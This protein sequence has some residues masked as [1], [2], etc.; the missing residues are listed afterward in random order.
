MT[1]KIAIVT[2]AARGIGKAITLRLLREG[3]KIMA[4]DKDGVGLESLLKELDSDLSVFPVNIA[5]YEHVERFF[6]Q[7]IESDSTPYA[8]VNNAGIFPGTPFLEY[9]KQNIEE[10]LDVNL[11]G[12]IFMTQLFGKL[13]KS[14]DASGVIVNVASIAGQ[15]GSA[16]TIYGISKAGVIGLTKNAAMALAPNIRVNAVA[17]SM[18]QTEL[19]KN[20]SA[21]RTAVFKR[22]ELLKDDIHPEDIANSV[23]FLIS[24]QSKH[25]TGATLDINN[26]F[27]LR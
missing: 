17:P 27:A 20:V 5:N 1:K 22:N 15:A 6:A 19:I 14:K 13:L 26:G 25:C 11:L 23:W 9:S 16:D 18:V 7:F 10:V 8:L 21:E 4:L 2:G 24:D 12:P 3:F